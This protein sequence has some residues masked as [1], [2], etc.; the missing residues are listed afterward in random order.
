MASPVS[1][2]DIIAVL[3]VTTKAYKSW[4]GAC[5]QYSDITAELR[6]LRSNLQRIQEIASCQGSL[7][8]RHQQQHEGLQSILTSGE[9]IA[10]DLDDITIKHQ[11]LVSNSNKRK[12]WERLRVAVKSIADLQDRLHRCN[13][14]ISTFMSVSMASVLHDAQ[15]H[16]QHI[17]QIHELVQELPQMTKAIEELKDRRRR[18]RSVISSYPED[19]KH[20]W[21][22]F[23]ED[24]ERQGYTGR[25]IGQYQKQIMQLLH[26]NT[27][28]GVFGTMQQPRIDED[29]DSPKSS[30]LLNVSQ[31][32]ES[33]PTDVA[34]VPTLNEQKSN[35]AGTANLGAWRPKTLYSLPTPTYNEKRIGF[36]PSPR[37]IQELDQTF[38]AFRLADRFPE[39]TR[40]PRPASSKSSDSSLYSSA[41]GSMDQSNL[42]YPN[43]GPKPNDWATQVI[44]NAFGFAID[45]EGHVF[46]VRHKIG[47][48]YLWLCIKEKLRPRNRRIILK[49]MRSPRFPYSV[50][51]YDYRIRGWPRAQHTDSSHH[52]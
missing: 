42:H 11:G 2:G 45:Q 20:I 37:S 33:A 29:N 52:H 15:P 31:D 14:S 38:A 51:G 26:D 39:T 32:A 3:T 19:D 48:P 7:L 34:K 47:M 9:A 24:L 40:S 22:Q 1:V 13:T 16:L 8:D 23:R 28:A 49:N 5:G 12:N 44:C 36:L 4:K 27:R 17:D 46:R 30:P 50:V 43:G 10:K 21:K 6:L 18:D 25:T 35:T 41:S